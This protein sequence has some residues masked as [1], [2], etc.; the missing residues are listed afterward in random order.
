MAAVL[1][2]AVLKKIFENEKIIEPM[3]NNKELECSKV[4]KE[5]NG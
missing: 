4:E 1:H 5:T 3:E 2:A